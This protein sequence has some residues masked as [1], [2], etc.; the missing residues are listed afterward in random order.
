MTDTLLDKSDKQ[1]KQKSIL[2]KTLHRD[3]PFFV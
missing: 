1:G 2:Q 3:N